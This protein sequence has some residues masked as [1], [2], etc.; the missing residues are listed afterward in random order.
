M[1]TALALLATAIASTGC[2]SE[3]GPGGEAAAQRSPPP[4]V[5]TAVVK[6]AKHD[7]AREVVL[8]VELW[9]WQQVSVV[10]KVTGYVETVPVDRGSVVKAGDLLATVSVPELEDEKRKR[11]AD[12]RVAEADVA[13]ATAE[14]E[15]QVL[16]IQRMDKLVADNAVS[17]QEYDVAKAREV[18]SKSAIAHAEARAA[19]ARES[20]RSTETWIA[21]ATIAAP[22]AG[23]LTDR[24]VHP[25]ALVS[26]VERTPLFHVVDIATIRAVVDVPEAEAPR[27]QADRTSVRVSIPEIAGV[28]SGTVSRSATALDPKTRTLRVEVDLKNPDRQLLP[29]MYGQA[30]LV[31]ELHKDVLTVPSTAVARSGNETVVFVVQDGKARKVPVKIGLDDGKLAEV[32]SGPGA[33]DAVAAQARGLSDGASVKVIDAPKEKR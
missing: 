32:Q 30:T 8:P 20:L 24:W 15:L 33:E 19:A 13:S 31:L 18:V 23:V 1:P 17:V 10:A 25:G 27:V 14:H 12:V 4:P 21:Y 9:A 16:T 7:V 3:G 22:F 26:S 11:A 5:E 28:F 2:P 6:P 29:R